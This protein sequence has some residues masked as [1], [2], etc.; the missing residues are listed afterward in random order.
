MSPSKLSQLARQVAAGDEHARRI[1]DHQ[2]VPLVE[3][4]VRRWLNHQQ[5]DLA[6]RAGDGASPVLSTDQVYRL[7]NA[8]C[9]RIVGRSTPALHTKARRSDE[10]LV[11][12]GALDT[13]IG[14]L[15]PA[16]R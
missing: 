9:A 12:N 11:A 4:V 13:L 15:L 3:T 14:S 8:V 6:G 10:T 16:A 5:R 2:I 7:T 1:F